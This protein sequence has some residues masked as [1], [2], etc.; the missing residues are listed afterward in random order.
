MR[1]HVEELE[2]SRLVGG[3]FA[4]TTGERVE[5]D[6]EEN[7]DPLGSVLLERIPDMD[8]TVFE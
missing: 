6:V 5:A 2:E 7:S 3:P 8:P 4:E 1:T